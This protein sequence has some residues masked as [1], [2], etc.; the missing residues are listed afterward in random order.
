MQTKI[1]Y[2]WHGERDFLYI[3]IRASKVLLGACGQAWAQSRSFHGKHCICSS[4]SRPIFRYLL[5]NTI[6]YIQKRQVSRSLLY[7]SKKGKCPDHR[8]LHFQ[9]C[10]KICCLVLILIPLSN[11]SS[12]LFEY[13]KPQCGSWFYTTL[14]TLNHRFCK[15]NKL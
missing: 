14:K 1:L 11:Y 7:T 10:I 4:I 8:K 6:I 2:W 15:C 3:I 9:H 12:N 5:P 13:W